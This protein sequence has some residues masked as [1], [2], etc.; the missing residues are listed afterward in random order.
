MSRTC[1]G[2]APRGNS[3]ERIACGLS[4][5]TAASETRSAYQVKILQPAVAQISP[6]CLSCLQILCWPVE[7]FYPQLQPVRVVGAPLK[8]NVKLAVVVSSPEA[9]ELALRVVIIENGSG[10]DY[11]CSH[12]DRSHSRHQL[13]QQRGRQLADLLATLTPLPPSGTLSLHDC[14]T[15]TISGTW[16]K[17]RLNSSSSV[18]GTIRGRTLRPDRNLQVV[19]RAFR[20]A[21]VA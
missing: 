3:S 12:Q 21:T 18:N 7:G 16:P 13:R 6:L 4:Q 5:Q 11:S 14:R 20:A 9:E 15:S 10:T 1:R 2:L 8:I 17:K 19:V